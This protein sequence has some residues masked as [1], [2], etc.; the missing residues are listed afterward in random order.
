MLNSYIRVVYVPRETIIVMELHCKQPKSR[1]ELLLYP[2]IDLWVDQESSV[3]L[4]DLIVDKFTKENIE[5]ITCSG[6]TLKGCT[7][8]GPNTLLK[9]LLYS[10]FNWIPG[11]R[12]IEK[13]TYRNMEVIWLLGDLK[14]DHWTICKFRRENKD[15]IR[16]AAIEF[17]KFLV[18]NGYIEGKTIVLDGSKMKAYAAR[19]MYSEKTLNDRI[20]NIEE[21]L[22]K[23]L[24]NSDET[25]E[26]ENRLEN[27]SKENEKLKTKI[28]KL[29]E[30]KAKLEV[31]KD[32][33]EKSDKNY[34]SLTD[35]DSTLMRSRDGKMACY[36]VQTGVDVKN[37]MIVLAEATTDACDIELLKD[38]F[39]NIKIQL[40]LV[41]SELIADAGYGNLSQINEIEENN[42]TKCIIPIQ[43]SK[44]TNKDNSNGIRFTYDEQN[45]QYTCPNNEKLKLH[46]ANCEQKNQIYNVYK[47]NNCKDCP[48]RD[49]CT[50]SKTGRIIKI[51]VNNQWVNQYKQKMTKPENRKKIKQRK[52]IVEHPYGTIKMIMGKFCFLLR[53]KHKVQIE[54]DLYSTVYNL[55]RLINIDNMQD[56]IHKVEKYY[57]KVA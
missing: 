11:S 51:S 15:M 1:N 17:R 56:L 8:Y 16:K 35:P 21:H 20:K 34:I 47:C 30:E 7:S 31:L 40:G 46:A 55:K 42:E 36:N 53:K 22:D 45:D 37:H 28:R 2:H 18:A 10:Y 48:L 13:E 19:E 29:E 41:P 23:Y 38:D 25:D 57:W 9:L 43:V 49:K 14:P 3:R 39:E 52:A 50:T 27:E 6:Q 26:L 33:L 4:I 44:A 12:R 32:Q 24:D 5:I 54:V